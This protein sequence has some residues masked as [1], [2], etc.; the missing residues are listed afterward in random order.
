MTRSRDGFTLIELMITVVILSVGILAVIGTVTAMSRFQSFSAMSTDLSD[1][2]HS[3]MDE[4]RS[5][6]IATLGEDPVVSPGGSALGC[7]SGTSS[8]TYRELARGAS[9]R[10][11]CLA[12]EVIENASGTPSGTRLLRLRGT[13][14]DVQSGP[15]Q[16]LATLLYVPPK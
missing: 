12:W 6:S 7:A 10:L 13:L 9:G 5:R 11:Y 4:L 16:N 8:T 3:K 1:L 15:V 14:V 2:A